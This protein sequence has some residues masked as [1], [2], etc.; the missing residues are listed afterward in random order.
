MKQ[1]GVDSSIYF[2]N[3]KHN[4]K[5]IFGFQMS[6]E[7]GFSGKICFYTNLICHAKFSFTQLIFQH[8][9]FSAKFGSGFNFKQIFSAIFSLIFLR[10]NRSEAFCVSSEKYIAV[11]VLRLVAVVVCYYQAFTNIDKKIYKKTNLRKKDPNPLLPQTAVGGSYII[12]L[13][14]L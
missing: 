13:V 14:F 5:L 9:V 8:K 1:T 2:T 7:I 11:N 10:K 12:F 3:L 6:H 4:I